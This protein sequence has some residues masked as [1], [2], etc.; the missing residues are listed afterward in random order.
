MQAGI[1]DNNTLIIAAILGI[2]LGNAI[3]P[4]IMSL[5]QE[6]PAR[7]IVAGHALIKLS[8]VFTCFILLRFINGLYD[9]LPG[10]P[11]FRVV[12]LHILFNLALIVVFSGLANRIARFFE[13]FYVNSAK[14]GEDLGPR[15]IPSL[16]AEPVGSGM[17]PVTAL[18]REILRVQGTIQIMIES[19][20]DMLVSG[21]SEKV[22]EILRMEEKVNLLFKAVRHYAV[23]LIRQG[24]SASDQKKV[25]AL[26]RYTASLENCGDVICKT[27][28]GVPEAMHKEGK[29]FSEEGKNELV[30]LFRY[31]IG[32]TE[33]AAELIMSWRQTTAQDLVQRKRELKAKCQESAQRHID[34][35][36][37]GVSDAM[38][39]SSAHLDLTMSLRWIN[40]LM[41]SLAYDAL[42]ET[43]AAQD[44]EPES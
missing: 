42:P 7:R 22:E 35:L 29:Q 9:L 25:T 5:N 1:T 24:L 8:G 4:I 36:S 38:Q 18:C 34:R 27:M 44:D 2:N 30:R 26:L 41:T 20:L 15:Y 11:G 3:P 14:I 19:T 12:T 13:R 6:A 28:I 39:S 43:E 40:T 23:D 33:L 21:K 31:L 10:M 32:S 17:L 37:M 16:N